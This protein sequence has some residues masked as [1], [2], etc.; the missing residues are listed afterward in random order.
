MDRQILWDIKTYFMDRRNNLDK[1]SNFKKLYLKTS[2][3]TFEMYL[4]HLFIDFNERK[5]Q[6]KRKNNIFMK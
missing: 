2:F 3:F 4:R 1:Y 5:I 6:Q